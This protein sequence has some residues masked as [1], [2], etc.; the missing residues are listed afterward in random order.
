MIAGVL[1][2]SQYIQF[3]GRSS[4]L[5]LIHVSRAYTHMIIELVVAIVYNNYVQA[6]LRS[7]QFCVC[8]MH[9]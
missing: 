1:M 2:D 4:I 9:T 6:W 3:C 8:A 7:S 5:R